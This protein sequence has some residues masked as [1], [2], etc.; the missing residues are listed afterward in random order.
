M[1]KK[2]IFG[3]GSTLHK[4]LEEGEEIELEYKPETAVENICILCGEK[5]IER[6]RAIDNFT[7][8]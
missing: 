2:R 6:K 4:S 5:M 7:P 1:K 3:I 8:C